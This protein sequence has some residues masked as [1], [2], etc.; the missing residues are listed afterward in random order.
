MNV[1]ARGVRRAHLWK[2]SGGGNYGIGSHFGLAGTTTEFERGRTSTPACSKFR[3]A[4]ARRVDT[5]CVQFPMQLQS[6]RPE[7]HLAPT[8][9]ALIVNAAIYAHVYTFI[10]HTHT[11]TNSIHMYIYIYICDELVSNSN[12]HVGKRCSQR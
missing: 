11:H 7:C 1:S 9:L 3:A 2:R 12:I 8:R 6:R 10:S 5:P 4:R